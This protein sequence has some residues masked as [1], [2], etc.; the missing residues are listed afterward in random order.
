MTRALYVVRSSGALP[1]TVVIPSRSAWRA[2]T[3]IAT[4][5]SWPGIAVEDQRARATSARRRRRRR[6]RGRPGGRPTRPRTSPPSRRHRSTGPTPGGRRR[7][8][9]SRSPAPGAPSRPCMTVY[10]SIVAGP[11]ASSP[12]ASSRRGEGVDLVL[13]VG[14]AEAA[15]PAARCRRRRTRA[16]WRSRR[17]PTRGPSRPAAGAGRCTTVAMACIDVVVPRTAGERQAAGAGQ[18]AVESTGRATGRRAARPTGST[19]RGRRWRCRR[20]R[21]RRARAPACRRA[22]WPACGRTCRGWTRT[23]ARGSRCPSA[24]RPSGPRRR[25]G[26]R[27]PRP[28]TMMIAAPM[29]TSLLE[30]MYLRYGRPMRRLL[31][32]VVRISSGVLASRIHAAGLSAAT[33]LKR[34]HSSLTAHEVLLGIAAGGGADRRLEHRVDLHRQVRR[35]ARPRPGGSC[36]GPRRASPA[37]GPRAPSATSSSAFCLRARM[38]VRHASPPVSTTMSTLAGEDLLRRRVDERLGRVAAGRRVGELARRLAEALGDDPAPGCR[39]S[40]TAS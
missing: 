36:R 40:T 26:A 14:V 24:G 22:R 4:A 39:T 16:S 23:G 11:A 29:S 2:A 18:L 28:S 25:R 5:S 33:S 3:T 30:F 37:A 10:A 19:S 32:D 7:A 17:W 21:R 35:P 27:P 20:C 38:R 1:A 12:L 34:D 6:R 9:R 13:R 8:G 15:R 31:A